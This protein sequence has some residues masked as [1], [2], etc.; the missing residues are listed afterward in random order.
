MEP[1]IV[2]IVGMTAS[3]K[4]AAAMQ[5]AQE[6]DGE[7]ICADSRTVYKGMDIGTAKPS[8]ADRQAARHHLLDIISPD[9]KFTV[10]D[11]QARA[12]RAITEIA[13]RGKLPIVVGGTGLYVDALIY[14]YSFGGPD[15]GQRQPLRPN[16]LVLG[17][18]LPDATIKLRIKG[19]LEQM[20][21]QGLATEVKNLANKYGWQSPGLSAIGYREFRGLFEPNDYKITTKDV[22]E[23][24][25]KATWQY[26]RRQR[27]W[28]R[29]NPD[30]YWQ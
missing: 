28:F 25:E 16:T 19:R 5:L 22:K 9:Q 2:V 26:A 13:E 30:I 29:R 17:T 11:F 12:N 23:Q 14:N 8:A 4:S 6:R 18:R 24:I 20:F 1:K 3:G 15:G 10:A 21:A 27:T 7:I